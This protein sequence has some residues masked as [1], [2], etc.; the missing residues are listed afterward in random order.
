M[1]DEAAENRAKLAAAGLIAALDLPPD[2]DLELF[3]ADLEKK[4]DEKQE[5]SERLGL[6]EHERANLRGEADQFGAAA[7]LFRDLLRLD[8]PRL[9]ALL[10]A[11]NI[12]AE[13]ARAEFEKRLREARELIPRVK[14]S[15]REGPLWEIL[16]EQR[17]QERPD[18]GEDP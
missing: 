15:P 2:L 14:S 4:Q 1:T 3:L 16:S 18:E 6:G 10:T 5:Q 12:S 7:G 9:T 17:G 13:E 11:G 8:I